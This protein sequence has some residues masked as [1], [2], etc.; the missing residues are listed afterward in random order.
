[1]NPPTL[2]YTGLDILETLREARVY[3]RYL[4]DL[5]AKGAG[6]ARHALDFGAGIGTFSELIRERGYRV[7]CVE[8]DAYLVECLR[9]K[10]FETFTELAELRDES[11]DYIFSL[12]VFEHIEDDRSVLR[13]LAAKL[14]R[15]GRILIYVPAF[16]SLWSGMDDR[17]HHY[18][19][20]TR[21]RLE[22]LVSSAGLQV[23]ECRYADSLGYLAALVF[24]FFGRRD[25]RLSSAAVRTYDRL[26]M[27][28]SI[29]L[30]KIIA[31]SF[32][33]NVYAICRKL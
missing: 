28:L 2:E 22:D 30:D 1:M 16:E 21:A 26:A 17:V 18:R 11:E 29:A 20:Y 9:E 31:G 5:C 32:G 8:S 14:R 12:N 13:A 6:G 27:P 25:G 10:G 23:E 15:G 3:N 4:T 7:R 33:K 24:K 19:R